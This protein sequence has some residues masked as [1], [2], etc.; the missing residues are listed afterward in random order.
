M[1]AG[2]P[3][4]LARTPMRRYFKVGG[5]RWSAKGR[6][7]EYGAEFCIFCISKWRVLADPETTGGGQNAAVPPP[8]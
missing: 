4:P 6:I 2:A 3:S 5:G 8:L 1:G 7:T